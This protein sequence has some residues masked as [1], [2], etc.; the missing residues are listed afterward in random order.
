ML[1]RT[2]CGMWLVNCGCRIVGGVQLVDCIWRNLHG[3]G[4]E[5]HARGTFCGV[6]LVDT[7]VPCVEWDCMTIMEDHVFN[8][9]GGPWVELARKTMT[10][11]PCVE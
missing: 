1:L 11:G 6:G 4:M 9:A 8:G 10:G 3:V 2:V 5:D 7:G